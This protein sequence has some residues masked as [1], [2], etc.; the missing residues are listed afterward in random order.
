LPIDNAKITQHL[1]VEVTPA[2]SGYASDDIFTPADSEM[3]DVTDECSTPSSAGYGA[4]MDRCFS[5]SS[6]DGLMRD[7]WSRSRYADPTVLDHDISAGSRGVYGPSIVMTSFEKEWGSDEEVLNGW[8]NGN[9]VCGG[10]T[11]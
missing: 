5:F 3:S 11:F 8:L 2:D 7:V 10:M 9:W 4:D 6:S 1:S